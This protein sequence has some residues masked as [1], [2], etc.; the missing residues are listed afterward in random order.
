MG[1][2]H[3]YLTGTAVETIEIGQFVTTYLGSSDY[4]RPIAVA[5]GTTAT[6]YGIVVLGVATN[7]A[8]AGEIVGIR[9]INGGTLE[10]RNGE[11]DTLVR[12]DN[13]LISAN[14][15]PTTSSWVGGIIMGG[16]LSD[17]STANE[18]VEVKMYHML[19]RQTKA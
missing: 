3:P 1:Y 10:T 12:G 9:G 19:T 16:C 15:W 8:A 17:S 13:L 2:R 14:G 7:N 5:D 11:G 18:I 4:E 6:G